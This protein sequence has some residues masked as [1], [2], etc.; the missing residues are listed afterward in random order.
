MREG[1]G[2]R[3]GWRERDFKALAYVVVGLTGPESFG[4]T[5]GLAIQVRV[6]AI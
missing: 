6:V 2:G 3:E 4:L 1:K 5:F